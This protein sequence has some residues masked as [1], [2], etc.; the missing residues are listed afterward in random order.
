MQSFGNE[1]TAIRNTSARPL[2]R[3]LRFL[4]RRAGRSNL[5]F[6]QESVAPVARS[7]YPVANSDLF[8]VQSGS[9]NVAASARPAGSAHG[10]H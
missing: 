9:V 10:P 5:A 3:K 2:L 8:I 4:S 1:P 7:G 6:V